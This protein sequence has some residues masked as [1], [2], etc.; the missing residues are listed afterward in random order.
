M[1]TTET[2]AKN[3]ISN[4]M[5]VDQ[6]NRAM[7]K[8]LRALRDL[9]VEYHA[10]GRLEQGSRPLNEG[11]VNPEELLVLQDYARSFLT[12]IDE[13]IEA[14]GEIMTLRG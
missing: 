10:H 1:N 13:A 11:Y 14:R 7:A 12:S 8:N 2:A 3:P 6:K 9:L 5:K 4:L